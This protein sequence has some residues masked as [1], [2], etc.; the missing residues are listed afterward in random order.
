[1][2]VG[3]MPNNVRAKIFLPFQSLTPF[4]DALL[5]ASFVQ[6]EEILISEDKAK[7]ID[8]MLHQLKRGMR[9]IFIY[10]DREDNNYKKIDE[11]ITKIDDINKNVLTVNNV[12]RIKDIY[13]ISIEESF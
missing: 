7:E 5:K 11:V 8:E 10:Y 4:H 1:M 2:Q 9:A 12:I 3:K 13:S 6:Q